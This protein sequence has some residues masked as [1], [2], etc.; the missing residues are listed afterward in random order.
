MLVE[1]LDVADLLT[2]QASDLDQHVDQRLGHQAGLATALNLVA[3][4]AGVAVKLFALTARRRARQVGNRLQQ[5]FGA[6]QQGQ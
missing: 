3:G 4:Q 2:L 1:Q 5:G 6:R